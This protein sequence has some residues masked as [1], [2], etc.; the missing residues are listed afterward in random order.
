MKRTLSLL[1][2]LSMLLSAAACSSSDDSDNAVD[3]TEAA[4][5]AA[6]TEP[7]DPR[8]AISDGLENVTYD[9]AT[10]TAYVRE[11]RD[12]KIDEETGDVVDDAVFKRELIVEERMK[13]EIEANL[14]SN[15]R[16]Q[17]MSALDTVI[18]SGDAVCSLYEGDTLILD[19]MG[20]NYGY[21][22]LDFGIDFSKPWW[23]QASVECQ[24][25]GGKLEFISSDYD[26]TLYKGLCVVFFNKKL[27]NDNNIGDMY[28]LVR[29]GKWTL[30]KVAEL[31]TT[32]NEDLNGDSKFDENDLFGLISGN[33]NMID[34]FIVSSDIKMVINDDE[35]F[36]KFNYNT[37]KAVAMCEKVF[38]LSQA[39][40]VYMIDEGK[41]TEILEPMFM[42]NKALF[43]TSLLNSA[44]AFRDMDTDFGI[45]PYP[46]YD[47]AQ[48]N[49]KTFSK[50]GFAALII[51]SCTA[52][53]QMSADVTTVLSA[54]SYK[55][56]VPAYYDTTLKTKT[57]RDN[58]SEEMLD[59]IRAG[60]DYDLAM[61]LLANT[62]NIMTMLRGYVASGN[63]RFASDIAKKETQ[64]Q[65]QL[66]KLS[67]NIRE[68]LA[69][70]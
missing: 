18:K 38:N 24:N 50:S 44:I 14:R 45:I 49:Y 48:E 63:F 32:I 10:F 59:I 12:F 19:A 64:V 56:V 39:K 66:D 22:W 31:S 33:G 68:S 4:T 23:S 35:G 5:T 57:S 2:A 20:Q 8:E 34:N 25:I 6:E 61:V 47:E 54:E 52:D 1:L 13:I 43:F 46:K 42:N 40:G 26:L 17:N 55:K 21:N 70:N 28:A 27:A 37:E 3:V 11:E 41:N 69:A 7:I 60:F 29:E 67:E 15:D 30:D 65:K 53:P 16:S 62:G 36:P 51:P 58:D 9:G